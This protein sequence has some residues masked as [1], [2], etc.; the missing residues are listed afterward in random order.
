MLKTVACS[1]DCNNWI[2]R[3]LVQDKREEN[4]NGIMND[5]AIINTESVMVV[6]KI[7]HGDLGILAVID[8][9]NLT[10]MEL[11]KRQQLAQFEL[12]C[13]MQVPPKNDLEIEVLTQPP[14]QKVRYIAYEITSKSSKKAP[15]RAE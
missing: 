5:A 6:Y 7:E 3:S 8:L 1:E 14:K 9:H 13:A 4:F 10:I 15:K 11:N 2:E 12:C